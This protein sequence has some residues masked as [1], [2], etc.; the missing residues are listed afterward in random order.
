[1]FLAIAARSRV[2]VLRYEDDAEAV[3]P[4][5]ATPIRIT[6]I[7]LRPRIVVAPGAPLDR[8]ARLVDRAHDGCYIANTINAE[9]VVEPTIE[10]A[11]G[12]TGLDAN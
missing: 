12:V 9:V 5:D 2:D 7:T 1:M 11:A 8:V 4:E 6:R 3:M 10:H